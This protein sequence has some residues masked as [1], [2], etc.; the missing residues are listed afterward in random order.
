MFQYFATA[1]ETTQ[2]S[3]RPSSYSLTLKTLRNFVAVPT[4]GDG[5]RLDSHMHN[6]KRILAFTVA[7]GL[8]I[9]AQSHQSPV[10]TAQQTRS[11][12]D[13]RGV[14]LVVL[15]DQSLSMRD[16][17][18]G[19]FRLSALRLL[20]DSLGNNILYDCP[21]VAHRLSVIAFGADSP[22]SS[23]TSIVIDTVTI[24]PTLDAFEVWRENRDGIRLRIPDTIPLIGGGTDYRAA[25]TAARQRFNIWQESQPDTS[26]GPDT[27]IRRQHV[28]LIADGGPCLNIVD[29]RCFAGGS[30][31]PYMADLEEYLSPSGPNFP[32]RGNVNPESIGIWFIA[33]NDL[34][35]PEFNYMA[36]SAL[37]ASWE[38]ITQGH[39]GALTFLDSSRDLG[40]VNQDISLAV[41]NI[42]D[43]ITGSELIPTTC[44]EPFYIEP[45]LDRAI[46]RILKIG[47]NATVRLEDVKV[48]IIYKGPKQP[49]RLLD[50]R[51][52]SGN[53]GVADYIADGPN[54]HYVLSSPLPGTYE[55]EVSG[56]DECRD[57]N[58]AYREYPL[59]GRILTP[60][61]NDTF[62]Q[63]D[64]SPFYDPNEP[65]YIRFGVYGLRD[66]ELIEIFS[67]PDFPL[68]LSAEIQKPDGGVQS[69]ELE[70]QVD[71]T[72]RSLQPINVAQTGDY[73]WTLTGTAVSADPNVGQ[74]ERFSSS[75]RFIVR[76]VQRFD[77]HIVE[78]QPGAS[79]NLGR[80]EQGRLV[81]TPFD[82]V[83]QMRET[84]TGN[85]IESSRIAIEPGQ[86]PFLAR[87]SDPAQGSGSI[88][89]ITYDPGRKAWIIRVTPGESGVP[90]SVGPQ[91][92]LLNLD[93]T[94]Y[95][96]QDFRP[97]ATGGSQATLQ[98]N[99]TFQL[100]S[101]QIQNPTG[102]IAQ[103]DEEPFY[104]PDAPVQFRYQVPEYTGDSGL[105]SSL[106]PS[107]LRATMI[108]R[109][110]NAVTQSQ[111]LV[112][113]GN[114]LW[115]SPD[116]IALP[117]HGSYQWELVVA[118]RDSAEDDLIQG[119]TDRGRFD[120]NR[121]GRYR[122]EL[123]SPTI[124]GVY[125]L[126]QI[127]NG[128]EQE[129]SLDVQVALIDTETNQR[130]TESDLT[131][132]IN[133]SQMVSVTI[134]GNSQ[135]TG[136]I[137]LN[138]EPASRTW[139]GMLAMNSGEAPAEEG[140]QT[141]EVLLNNQ[142]V[143]RTKYRPG[144][145][146]FTQGKID[147]ER[148]EL[149]PLLLQSQRTALT[150][151]VYG[152]PTLC[153]NAQV[154]PLEVQL[155]IIR[156]RG[157]QSVIE[158][159]TVVRGPI[160][161]IAKVALI[162]PVSR[163]TLEEGRLELTSI[164]GVLGLK[165]IVGER[166]IRSGTYEIQ[167]IPSNEALSPRYQFLSTDP[168]NIAVTRTASF[169]YAPATCMGIQITGVGVAGLLIFYMGFCW[170]RRPRGLLELVNAR[171]VP[172]D[173][174]PL[175]RHPS[176]LFRTKQQIKSVPD[177]AISRIVVSQGDADDAISINIYEKDDSSQL[178]AIEA[179]F[180]SESGDEMVSY[181]LVAGS[182]ALPVTRDTSVRYK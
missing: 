182:E 159:A 72:W 90:V 172:V 137:G 62:A 162:D 74:K 132:G 31:G 12:L 64:E 148:V 18:P 47:S 128:R 39:E 113:T 130:L 149:Q 118:A 179:T 131:P 125:P 153:Y 70:E 49:A 112:H 108:L 58:V 86:T 80:I 15:L 71:G 98:I 21:G 111:E 59:I 169:L 124:G 147:F 106:P 116:P 38:R 17:D 92:V 142:A 123:L 14:D 155:P 145:D 81:Y 120:V 36:D 87:V 60:T 141:L 24:A 103:Y 144:S 165:A 68:T 8:F 133:P 101:G 160:E 156:A 73:R 143:D 154:I 11:G 110:P 173:A 166:Y 35:Q 50:G 97:S 16:N 67:D 127:V 180:Y 171:G 94:A 84:D 34:T 122:I 126:N 89:T 76:P 10:V 168:I 42:A 175:G 79:I 140:F 93:P 100:S 157:S 55:V 45:Y 29:N 88:P 99:Q 158:P 163:E 51:V 95:K 22:E 115:E 46:I 75:G 177:E 63:F 104:D 13:C 9:F 107:R 19:Q 66:D 33:M 53:I 152:G 78:P 4:S 167:I 43:R 61:T 26:T 54:E 119:F 150:T 37:R 82:I 6:L 85:P 164:D 139:R 25:F 96:R 170:T 2:K 30:Q 44:T 134:Q 20:I 135:A 136:P 91:T 23:A 181:T 7:L 1:I 32:W 48:A 56:A 121:V 129:L 151:A 5:I 178:R 138:Y 28:V 41:A 174:Y 77:I 105:T 117:V 57:L 52:A 146:L 109:Q 69:I 65:D 114:G 27:S 83:V 176:L 161:S 3:W 102:A 40:S